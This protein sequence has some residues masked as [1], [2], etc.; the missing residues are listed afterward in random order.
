M[1]GEQGFPSE[2]FL[3]NLKNDGMFVSDSLKTLYSQA[4]RAINEF[5][6]VKS[7]EIEATLTEP[8]SLIKE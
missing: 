7:F 2:Q 6:N 8:L 3:N 4:P 5:R 1:S